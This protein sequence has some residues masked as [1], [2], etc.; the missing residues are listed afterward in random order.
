MTIKSPERGRTSEIAIF[1]RIIRAD[2]GDLSGKLARYILTLGFDEA[3]QQR[4]R[5]LAQQRADFEPGHRLEARHAQRL[6]RTLGYGFRFLPAES[7]PTG[8]LQEGRQLVQV[9]RREIGRAR[10]TRAVP[11]H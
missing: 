3:D 10:T 6:L 4:M 2:D 1:A 7:L 9:N 8:L 11:E 5:D